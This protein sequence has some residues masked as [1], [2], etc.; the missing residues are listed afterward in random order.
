MLMKSAHARVWSLDFIKIEGSRIVTCCDT[1]LSV[2]YT[3]P[4]YCD[5]ISEG[6]G[7]HSLTANFF[8]SCFGTSVQLE[9]I[10]STPN[11]QYM[12]LTTLYFV[13]RFQFVKQNITNV[14]SR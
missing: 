14:A 3:T 6:V 11:L 2:L 12:R 7:G 13:S 8:N 1:M 4:F 5:R 10:F 9:A